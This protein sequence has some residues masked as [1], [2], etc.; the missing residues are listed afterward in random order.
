[1]QFFTNITNS[2]DDL[3]TTCAGEAFADREFKTIHRAIAFLKTQLKNADEQVTAASIGQEIVNAIGL[4]KN[5]LVQFSNNRNEQ[6]FI[7]AEQHCLQAVRI[8]TCIPQVQAGKNHEYLSEALATNDEAFKKLSEKVTTI[9]GTL[10]TLE[11]DAS[12]LIKSLQ[13]QFNDLIDG[14]SETLGMKSEFSEAL[15]KIEKLFEKEMFGDGENKKGWVASAKDV[16]S[17]LN[18]I[19][20]DGIKLGRIIGI[21]DKTKEQR[22]AE[23]LTTMQKVKKHCTDILHWIGLGASVGGYQRRANV[24]FLSSSLWTLAIIGI[25]GWLIWF[26]KDAMDFVKENLDKNIIYPFLLFRLVAALPF[27]AFMTFAGF[28]AKHH[29]AMELKYR[30]FELELAAFEPNLATLPESVRSFAKLMFVQKTFGNIEGTTVEQ[31]FGLEE[32][33]KLLTDTKESLETAET[34]IKKAE[35]Q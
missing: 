12:N 15:E 22:Q 32:L 26:N 24:E 30:Q 17:Q 34:V 28:K 27:V 13:D 8:S 29:R 7:N 33:K 9:T 20:L 2:I 35:G 5:E 1:M 19:L 16:E 10:T 31:K 14:T 6:H 25:F 11:T 4:A 21:D 3:E 18:S 23:Q